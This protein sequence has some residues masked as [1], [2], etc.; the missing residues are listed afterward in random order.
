MQWLAEVL[1]AVELPGG[2]RSEQACAAARQQLLQLQGRL[3][4]DLQESVE[5][6]DSSRAYVATEASSGASGQAA[7]ASMHEQPSAVA[8]EVPQLFKLIKA[9]GG[10]LWAHF[11]LPHCCNNPGCVD[12]HGASELQLVGRKGCVCSRCR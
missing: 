12:L 11:P 3:Q 5:M 1:P 9:F 4:Q 2:P 10:A 7:A 8:P 6:M